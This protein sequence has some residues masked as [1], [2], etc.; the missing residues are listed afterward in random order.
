MA[1][2]KPLN[3]DQRFLIINLHSTGVP[4]NKLIFD[5]RLRRPNDLNVKSENEPYI[6]KITALRCIRRWA[7]DM[8]TEAKKSTGRPRKI[9]PEVEKS[10]V[11]YLGK[12][13]LNANYK[14]IKSKFNLN[15]DRRTV[16]N[17]GLRNGYRF[18]RAIKKPKLTSEVLKDR[19]KFASYWIGKNRRIRS[20]IN[21]DEKTFHGTP[22]FK[23]SVLRRRGTAF[24]QQNID[25][26][27]KSS[28]SV[29]VWGHIGK[30][31]ESFFLLQSLKKFKTN[32]VQN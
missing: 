27:P 5:H 15:C 7:K 31:L 4:I 23:R 32:F 22:K 17:V 29:N 8:S 25:F 16:N 10:I 24:E 1:G 9:K 20:I 3:R 18:Y 21:S 12:G 28:L 30:I 2:A 26:K 19:F 13:R 14:E 6:S 11:D